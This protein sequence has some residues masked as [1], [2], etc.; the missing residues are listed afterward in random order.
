MPL[1]GDYHNM[2]NGSYLFIYVHC[3]RFYRHQV[4]RY[5]FICGMGKSP[6]SIPFLYVHSLSYNTIVMDN[7]ILF[8]RNIALYKEYLLFKTEN[9][10]ILMKNTIV[11]RFF[12]QFSLISLRWLLFLKLAWTLNQLNI[13]FNIFCTVLITYSTHS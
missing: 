11:K 9:S 12:A 5:T 13:V 1:V 7:C 2:W 10:Q 8:I 6:H 4:P 3:L